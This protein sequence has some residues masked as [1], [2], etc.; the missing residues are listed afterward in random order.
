MSIWKMR[1]YIII[2]EWTKISTYEYINDILK[3]PMFFWIFSIFIS[4]TT[5]INSSESI[6]ISWK[7]IFI[8]FLFENV[9]YIAI[10][11]WNVY[12]FEIT[13]TILFF[14]FRYSSKV[15]YRT[16]YWKII[17]NLSKSPIIWE[18]ME[19]TGISLHTNILLK[20]IY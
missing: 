17:F 13:S 10:T 15:L 12:I 2:Q 18:N 5:I 9:K 6:I 16:K 11:H 3:Y 20:A 7:C 8:Q 1:I 4:F 14:P 19:T